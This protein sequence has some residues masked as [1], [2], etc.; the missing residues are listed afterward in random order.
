MR[1]YQSWQHLMIN[2]QEISVETFL[3]EYWQKKPVIIRNALPGFVNH[4]APDELAGLAL[5]DDIESRIVFETPEQTPQWHLKRGPFTERDFTTLPTSHWTLL[6]QGVDRLIPEIY[7]ILNHFDFIPQW[8]I[9]DVMISYAALKGSVGPHYDNYDVF[10]YQAMGRR[11]WSLT[12][13]Q[14][15]PDNYIPELELRI[16]NEFNVEQR[17]MLEEGDMLYLP[18]HIGHY[19][20]AQSQDCMTYSFGYRSYQGQELWDSLGEH[21][22][23]HEQFKQLYQDPNW[24]QLKHTAEIQQPAWQQAQVLLHQ[25]INDERTM[26]SWFGCFATRLDQQAEQQLP[27]PIE[28]D[29]LPELIDFIQS[30]KQETGLERDPC[31]RFAYQL[32]DKE[33]E[34]AFYINGCQWQINQVSP[35]LLIY[36]ANNRFLSLEI[37]NKY[38]MKT[39]DQ[40]FIFDMWRLQWLQIAE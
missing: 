38:L 6:V 15:T 34:F 10:L 19:G 5:E 28:E 16:M 37:L 14:C 1:F 9:D 2:F 40:S 4:L 11:E 26:K 7:A 23:E 25:L 30:L 27:A 36:V 22:S 3:T 12:S 18:P 39:A 20:I 35:E 24:S 33:T 17:F 29:E 32:A 21:A 31:C 13:Q 8:R